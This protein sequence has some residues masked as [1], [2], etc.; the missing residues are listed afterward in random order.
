MEMYNIN[1]G[2]QHVYDGKKD[3]GSLKPTRT[4]SSIERGSEFKV[5]SDT[6]NGNTSGPLARDTEA[7]RSEYAERFESIL[8][9]TY[10]DENSWWNAVD[11]C[12]EK[13]D[14]F[15]AKVSFKN[16]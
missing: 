8:T 7:E 9:Q 2:K 16:N 6:N 3:W 1:F 11:A 5:S 13:D 10:E 12:M 4:D 14:D 15:K